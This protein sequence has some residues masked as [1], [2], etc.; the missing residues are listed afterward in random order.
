M[1]TY[2]V[3]KNGNDSNTGTEAQPWKTIQ[4]AANGAIA[5]DTIYIRA[6]QYNER[7]IVANSGRADAWITFSAYQNEKVIIDGTGIP[8]GYDRGLFD[9]TDRSYI[10]VN[11]LKVQNSAHSGIQVGMYAKHINI[12][13]CQI[14]TTQCSGI[15]INFADDVKAYNNEVEDANR[16]PSDEAITIAVSTNVDVAFNHIHDCNYKEGIDIKS[17][18]NN[19]KVHHNLV[20]NIARMGIYIDGSYNITENVQTYNNEV[21]NCQNGIILECEE[22]GGGLNN[23]K[24]F[25]NVIHDIQYYGVELGA[26]GGDASRRNIL[27]MNNT[28]RRC[29]YGLRNY[30]RAAQLA[31][32]VRIFNNIF[33]NGKSILG[34]VTASSYYTEDHNLWAHSAYADTIGRL[35]ANSP[36][37]DAGSA[38]NAPA[39][40][41]D[42]KS[43]GTSID[44][45][46][47]EYAG[48]VTTGTITGIVRDS[49]TGLPISGAKITA[50]GQTVTTE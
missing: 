18:G 28:V 3:A 22:K 19:I 20:H 9:L 32:P 41:F 16:G 11:N 31:G 4:K 42:D 5:G 49:I 37:I 40:D 25:N 35:A 43:R 21:Y 27:I 2:Y 46:A 14:K 8:V 48:T 33:E 36:A 50:G 13:K 26:A 44:I 34:N 17:G 38:V 6:G 1:T 24:V 39:T 29:S 23:I 12:E 10:K 47:F 7:V 15:H 45:G 30:L